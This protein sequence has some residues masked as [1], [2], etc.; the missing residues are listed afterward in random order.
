MS[1]R[2]HRVYA[3]RKQNWGGLILFAQHMPNAHS[4][5]VCFG[6]NQRKCFAKKKSN[7]SW[8]ILLRT[9]FICWRAHE[10]GIFIVLPSKF[11]CH[12][13]NI[14][15]GPALSSTWFSSFRRPDISSSVFW[16]PLLLS[17][18]YAVKLSGLVKIFVQ[19]THCIYSAYTMRCE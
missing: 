1:R 16:V 9:V 17:M 11:V 12:V 6:N 18:R 15:F 8:F 14:T 13:D 10:H 5:V 4:Y 19:C 2:A 7:P 3:S